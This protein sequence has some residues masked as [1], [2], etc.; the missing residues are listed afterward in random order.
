[1]QVYYYKMQVII[2]LTANTAASS[3]RLVKIW[4]H[5]SHQHPTTASGNNAVLSPC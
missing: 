5:P 1:M 2:S 4:K 3:A